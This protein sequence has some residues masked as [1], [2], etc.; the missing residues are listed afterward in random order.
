MCAA[1]RLRKDTPHELVNC[2]YMLHIR[3]CAF[4]A[5]ACFTLVASSVVEGPGDTACRA[6][7]DASCFVF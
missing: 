2:Y 5:C 7:V 6:A 4:V 3:V 1:L